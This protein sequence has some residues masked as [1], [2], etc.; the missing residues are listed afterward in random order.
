MKK[1]FY[2]LSLF[3]AAGL[4][5][6]CNKQPDT[7]V[8]D[9]VVVDEGK[10]VEV[11][12]S[13]R[14]GQGTKGADPGYAAESKVNTL[15]VFVFKDNELEAHRSVQGAM[16]A[17]IPATAGERSVWAVVNAP[18]LY[19]LL[20]K[21][22]QDPMTLD[23]LK[24]HMTALGENSVG[25]FVM[26]GDVKQ[27]LVDGGN[28]VVDVRRVVARVN[29][30]KISASLK[31]Y[32]EAFSV[33]LRGIY[34]INAAGN[35]SYDMT[36][37]ATEWFNKLA[38]LDEDYDALL[39][40]NLLTSDIIVRNNEYEKDG[41]RIK[42]HEAYTPESIAQGQYVLAE[43]VTLKKD[44]SY[45]GDHVFYPYPNKYGN[46][47]GTGGIYDDEW[48]PRG[49]ILVLEAEMLDGDGNPIVLDSATGQ[50]IGYYPLT[51]PALERNKTYSIDEV[52]ITR[53]PGLVPYKPIETG[54]SQV[55]ITVHDWELGL[56][57]GTIN[58]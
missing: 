8:V 58:I 33:K 1:G 2:F 37:P 29:I 12:V 54:E 45:M 46:N 9:P 19:E 17:L 40:D 43:G 6:S 44:N 38:H 53:L 56:N 42:E 39:Y 16:T 30:V 25:N 49:S 52:R 57:I 4:V 18:D 20:N 11:T 51:L 15:Q 26:A 27:E 23:K 14:G 41:G 55:T 34:I 7:P 36:I 21:S 13:I 32:R 50:T 35:V 24:A 48:S 31:D 5:A 22:D 3:V 28:V 47:D 10:A